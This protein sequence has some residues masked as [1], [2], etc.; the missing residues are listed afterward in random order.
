MKKT[1]LGMLLALVLTLVMAFAGC[2]IGQGDADKINEAAENNEY[3]TVGE[4]KDKYGA[5]TVDLTVTVLGST[6]GVMIWVNGCE[7]LE[8]V[9]AKIDAEEDVQG[10]YVVV[11]NNNATSASYKEITSEDLK[12]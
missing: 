1:F 3:V 12:G 7:N 11:L 4:L 10:L 8:E 2:G 6:N 9:E 5:A